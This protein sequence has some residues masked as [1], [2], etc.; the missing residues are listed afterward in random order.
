MT[1]HVISGLIRRRRE[2]AGDILELLGR[3]DVLA[4]DLETIGRALKLFDPDIQLDMIP[5][6]QA[7][8]K[9][10]WALRGEVVRAIYAILRDASEPMPTRAVVAAVMA[11]R[12]IAGEPDRVQLKRVRKC[13][14]RQRERGT[15]IGESVGGVLCW[16]VR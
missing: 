2:L 5:A 7:R 6:L 14:D 10:D 15:L 3:V 8:P 1:D 13:L 9:P 16:R 12:G 11:R 4:N